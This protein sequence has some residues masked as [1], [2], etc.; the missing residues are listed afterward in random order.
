[1]LSVPKIHHL[2]DNLIHPSLREGIDEDGGGAR[3]DNSK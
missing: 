2:C 1:M 3:D